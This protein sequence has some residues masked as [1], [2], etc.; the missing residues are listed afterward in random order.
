MI[1]SSPQ[2]RRIYWTSRV[3]HG[4]VVLS[5]LAIAVALLH[6]FLSNA[7]DYAVPPHVITRVEPAPAAASIAD[8]RLAAWLGVLP[9]LVLLYGFYRL[10]RMMRACERGELFSSQVPAHLQ[11]FS[12][13]IVV[14][15]LLHIS[16]PAQIALAQA[17]TGQ[18][19]GDIRL[20]I[21]SEQMWLLQLALL[22]MFLASVIREA[23]TIAEDN[24]KI[25]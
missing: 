13:A 7:R 1:N 8:P 5:M 15:E 3:L 10:A 18:A 2:N 25:I 6:P 14:F 17:A 20:V 11:V 16:L 19:H 9:K 12:L 21:T 23:A 4:L 22:F 24:A